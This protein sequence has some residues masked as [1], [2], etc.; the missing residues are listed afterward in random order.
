MLYYQTIHAV[1]Q[2]RWGVSGLLQGSVSQP[3]GQERA[4]VWQTFEQAVGEL[5]RSLILH[6]LKL[7]DDQ[8]CSARED[9]RA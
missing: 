4:L 5:G 6:V 9:K 8:A 1:K 3:T 2:G 7:L